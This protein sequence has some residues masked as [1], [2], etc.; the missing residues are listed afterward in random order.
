MSK[1]VFDQL[2]ER[3]YKTGIEQG[4][5]FVVDNNGAYKKGVAFNGLINFNHSPEGAEENEF[6]ADNIKYLVLRS[7]ENFKATLTCYFTPEEF[8]E[9]DGTKLLVPGVKIRGQARRTFGFAYI[10]K[11]GNDT[12]GDSYGEILHLIYGCTV[13]P[14]DEEHNTINE[15]PE[16][17]EL[18]YDVSSTPIP[19]TGYKAVSCIEIDSTKVSNDKWK[20]VIDATYGTDAEYTLT[21]DTAIDSSKTY[22]TR[23]GSEG[24][25]TYTQV[26]TPQVSDIGTYYELT[27]SATDSRLL[28]PSDIISMFPSTSG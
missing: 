25:Y 15:T 24:S 16:P 8:D 21:T 7:A 18:S 20:A 6:Y 5:L 23:S 22:Y 3:K 9:C 10:S 28:L 1:L 11:I 26:T 13:S 12:V 27:T 14:S 4:V 19:V 17:Q 2:G